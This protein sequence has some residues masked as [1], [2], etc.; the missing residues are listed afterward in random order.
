MK[1]KRLLLLPTALLLAF[2]CLCACGGDGQPTETTA[3]DESDE[4]AGQLP[5]DGALALVTDGKLN[6]RLVYPDG[7]TVMRDYAESV[8]EVI[9][10]LAG[11]KPAVQQERIAESTGNGKPSIYFGACRAAEQLGLPADLQMGEYRI[12]REGENA[13]VLGNTSKAM[14]AAVAQ[15]SKTIRTGKKGTSITLTELDRRNVADT[16]A[17]KIPSYPNAWGYAVGGNAHETVVGNATE[18]DLTAYLARLEADGYVSLER[19]SVQGLEYA[20]MKK[21]ADC[22][23]VTL[24]CGELRTIYEPAEDCWL[25]QDKLETGTYRTAGYLMGV[26]GSGTY[27]NGLCMFYLL[28]DGS[29]VVF[30]GG[31]NAGDAANLYKNLRQVAEKNGIQSIRIAALIVTHFH[32]DHCGFFES[33]VNSYSDVRIDRAVLSEISTDLGAA[34]SEG[35]SYSASSISALQRSHPETRIVRLHTG[36][37]LTLGDMQLEMLYTPA[38]LSFGSLTDYNDTSMVMRLTV[39]GKSILM[40][41]DAATAT[42]NLLSK[43]YGR[44]LHSD[45]LQVPHHGANGGGTIEAYALIRPTRLYW[46]AGEELLKFIKERN[47]PEIAAYLLGLVR[48]ENVFLAGV[49]GKLTEFFFE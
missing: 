40:T 22:L 17:A 29:F 44:Y 4:T 26:W 46:P 25:P 38:D 5:T 42:W 31:H 10:G 20:L 45:Y 34:A 6:Y 27:Q 49:D 24:S 41:G 18:A 8:A 43:K 30:D 1:R 9:K 7:N 2:C 35:T 19:R 11:T 37:V 15:L 47:N 28:S 36:Q 12:V 33:F 13:F 23:F 3:P 21:D 32:G 14:N 16:D 39:N 48:A